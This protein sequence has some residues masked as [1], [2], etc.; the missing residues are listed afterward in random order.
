MASSPAYTIWKLAL[1]QR[2]F[3]AFRLTLTADNLFN[4]RPKTYEY[5]SPVTEGTTFSA[6]VAVD[7]EKLF[8]RK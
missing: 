6:T 7:I 5:N 3:N 8:N 4:Y 2:F 1:S